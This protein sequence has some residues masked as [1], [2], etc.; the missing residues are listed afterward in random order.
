[1][2]FK[3]RVSELS[4][5]SGILEYA[6]DGASLC[7]ETLKTCKIILEDL[8]GPGGYTAKDLIDLYPRLVTCEIEIAL[9]E[10]QKKV[11]NQ[12]DTIESLNFLQT[13]KKLNGPS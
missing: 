8:M 2:S 10:K 5:N 6:A 12:T 9:K 7:Y 1:M 3:D 11:L 4:N 13:K